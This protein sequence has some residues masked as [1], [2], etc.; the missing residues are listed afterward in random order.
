MKNITTQNFEV[1]IIGAGIV[2]TALFSELCRNGVHCVL[3]EANEDVSNGSSKANSGIIH[4]GYDPLPGTLMA[5]YNILGNK[6]YPSMCKRLGIGYKQC[7]T[8]VVGGIDDRPKLMQLLERGRHNGVP[9]L[10]ILGKRT[11]KKIEPNLADRINYALYAPTGG[12]VS[13]YLVCVALAEEGIIN[14]G[15]VMCDF[16]VNK[17]CYK[18]NIYTICGNELEYRKSVQ[19][20]YIVNCA[21]ANADY[22]NTLV[23]IPSI[24]CQYVKGEYI[25]LDKSQGS[26]VSRPIFPLPTSVG[27][28]VLAIPTL[29]GNVMF[30]PT[31]TPCTATD[32]SVEQTGLDAIKQKVILSVKAP[33]FRK[34]IKLFAG[35]RAKCGNDFVIQ[36]SDIAKN[37]YYA[38]GIQSPGL[39][40]GPAIALDLCQKLLKDGVQATPIIPKKRTPYPDVY[41]MTDAQKKQ[42]IAK[43]PDYGKII[44]RCENISLGEIIDAIHSPLHPTSIDAIKRRIRPS[45]GRCQ[46]SFCLPKLIDII[47]TTCKI[48]KESVTLCGRGSEFI[49]GELKENGIFAKRKKE[50]KMIEKLKSE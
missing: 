7:G 45:M 3:L 28:G 27:K 21:G 25:L 38:M 17:I 31:A 23:G 11:L 43:N 10:R 49:T 40:A 24:P 13:P 41:S 32:T 36:K 34:T 9:G 18:N 33:N 47:S 14:G 22:I 44:C 16:D 30:G 1:A 6:M 37:Y 20:R 39:T 29:H 12:I 5:K 4:A 19:A 26:F 2:G 15:T 35:V 50:Q 46:G 8:L 42:L 48:P